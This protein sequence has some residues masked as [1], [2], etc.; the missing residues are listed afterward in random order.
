MSIKLLRNKKSMACECENALRCPIPS[1]TSDEVIL[2]V[3]AK[4]RDASIEPRQDSW[5]LASI[6]PWKG[7]MRTAFRLT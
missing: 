3:S 6:R 5:L 2:P 1:F 4:L 7:S